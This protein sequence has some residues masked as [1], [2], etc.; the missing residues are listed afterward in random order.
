MLISSPSE[1]QDNLAAEFKSLGDKILAEQEK[2]RHEND[3]L[4][5]ERKS[6]ESIY[7]GSESSTNE[8]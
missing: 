7:P 3:V 5:N 1:I 6:Q 2:Y 4:S 8:S